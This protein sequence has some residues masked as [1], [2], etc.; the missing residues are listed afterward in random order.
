[1]KKIYIQELKNIDI[2][3]SKNA[4]YSITKYAQ[5]LTKNENQTIIFDE[6]IIELNQY[7]YK[8]E[9][10]K[11]SDKTIELFKKFKDSL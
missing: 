4:A 1:M 10:I 5:L 8:K 2:T 11:F 3:K 9:S 7:K 6:L